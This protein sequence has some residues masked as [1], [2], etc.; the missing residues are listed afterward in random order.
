MTQSVLVTKTEREIWEMISH[1]YPIKKKRLT[2]LLLNLKLNF[3]LLIPDNGSIPIDT[4]PFTK[5]VTSFAVNTW[6]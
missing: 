4:L 6:E 5:A 1:I 3:S 2:F